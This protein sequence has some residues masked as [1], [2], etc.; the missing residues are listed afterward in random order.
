MRD[1]DSAP[2][3]FHSYIRRQKIGCPSVGPIRLSSGDWA[4]TPAAISEELAKTFASVFRTNHLAQMYPHQDLAVTMQPFTILREEVE[5]KIRRLDG[6]KSSDPDGIH[7]LMLK[8]CAHEVSWPLYL[9][10]CKSFSTGEV[11]EQWKKSIVV[12]IFKGGS[13]SD[14]TK[15]RPISLTS[16]CCR[17]MERLVA[18]HIVD[19]LETN[20]ILSP[21]QFAFR[22]GYSTEDQLVLTYTEVITKVDQGYI[23]DMIYLD[24]AKAFDTISHRI[25]L[26]KL[27]CLGFDNTLLNWIQAFL[28]GRTMQVSTAGVNSRSFPVDSG[29]PQGSVLGPVLFNIYINFITPGLDC[30]FKIF[31]DD[32]KLYLNYERT[33]LTHGITSLQRNLDYVNSV[34]RSLNRS[35]N[36]S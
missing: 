9:I 14:P 26:D 29:V 36:P 15:Y 7:P 31:A 25:L 33:N 1:F 17:T 28:T 32:F 8:S 11:P 4:T 16:L 18:A 10:F 3:L 30:P 6:S 35:L 23:V 13:R 34:R 27:R 20:S 21:N 22:T 5:K 24:F 12:P 2:R 19:Y